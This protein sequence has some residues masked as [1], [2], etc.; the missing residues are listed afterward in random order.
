MSGRFDDGFSTTISFSA[1]TS[2]LMF[3]K[4]VTPPGLDGGG[5]IETS[6]MLNTA[7]RTA[8]AKSLKT[9]T[10]ASATVAYEHGF[11]AEILAMINV[12]QLITITFPDGST[13]AFYGFI[14]TFAPGAFVEGEQPTAEISIEPTNVHSTTGVETAP[15]NTTAT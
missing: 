7:Y 10:A 3:E 5:S 8:A 12:N 15:A 6:T 9:L 13:T 14:N 2:V 1:D 4:E 11:L